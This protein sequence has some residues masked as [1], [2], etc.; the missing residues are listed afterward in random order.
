MLSLLGYV[1]QYKNNRLL[2]VM[3]SAVGNLLNSLVPPLA[4]TGR[5]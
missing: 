4:S 2:Y 5:E 1:K 3:A